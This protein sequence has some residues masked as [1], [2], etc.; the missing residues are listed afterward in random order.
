MKKIFLFL[1]TI[2]LCSFV[3]AAPASPR[4]FLFSYCWYSQWNLTNLDCEE[5]SE[6]LQ[7][8]YTTRKK[9]N[10]KNNTNT[11]AYDILIKKLGNKLDDKKLTKGTNI[12]ISYLIILI[13]QDITNNNK[14]NLEVETIQDWLIL[15]KD[16]FK[17]NN[18][19]ADLSLINGA[20]YEAANTYMLEFISKTLRKYFSNTFPYAKEQNITRND[21]AIL[22]TQ[23]LIKYDK[24][25]V[26]DAVAGKSN[27]PDDAKES[28]IYQ[29]I[30]YWLEFMPWFH[31]KIYLEEYINGNELL[32]SLMNAIYFTAWQEKV[33]SINETNKAARQIGITTWNEVLEQN[34]S[35][36]QAAIF[37]YRARMNNS[38]NPEFT[39]YD[40]VLK[41]IF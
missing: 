32:F 19:E 4:E 13:Q 34:I 27:Y 24:D 5:H 33:I 29:I 38:N 26:N 21:L 31:N 1:S 15:H 8:V 2:L 18:Q 12:A 35:W 11:F 17:K 10:Q 6:T 14:E 25:M 20:E 23:Y 36:A 9:Y 3:L 28:E 16:F 7:K 40:D 22:I 30:P 37:F 39:N 41:N